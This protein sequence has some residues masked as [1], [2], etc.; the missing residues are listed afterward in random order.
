M[1]TRHQTTHQ[2]T[3]IPTHPNIYPKPIP[4]MAAASGRGHSRRRRVAPPGSEP[5][6]A[7]GL[8]RQTDAGPLS[9]R[10]EG[11]IVYDPSTDDVKICVKRYTNYQ[12]AP[13]Y[14][15]SQA[16]FEEHRLK[17]SEVLT[18]LSESWATHNGYD[19]IHSSDSSRSSHRSKPKHSKHNGSPTHPRTIPHNEDDFKLLSEMYDGLSSEQKAHLKDKYKDA[20]F[21][22]NRCQCCDAYM[23][24]QYKCIHSD[25][26]GMCKTC[27]GN[28]IAN[29]VES[30]PACKKEQKLECPICT[31]TK[32]PNEML[33]SKN[34]SH[35]ICLA[36]FADS[37][38]CGK[39]ISK[40]PMCR[41]KFH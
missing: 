34:C 3:Y 33:M 2:H 25:C 39:T 37:Y 14:N 32:A 1:Q 5:R 40:C 20:T 27:H 35:G 24:S 41:C 17:I 38:R 31:E 8:W 6:E 12:W 13:I 15:L 30:C 18:S 16:K 19:V 9:Y 10:D 7:F 21:M 26:S 36:C 29:G 11:R 4:N 28:S 22:K 23:S